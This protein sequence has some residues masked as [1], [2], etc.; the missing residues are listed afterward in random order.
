MKIKNKLNEL[1]Q[2]DL[3]G[4][5][6]FCKY[7]ES[8]K[9]LNI[10]YPFA[11]SN[12]PPEVIEAE[13]A[14]SFLIALAT[15]ADTL[16]QDTLWLGQADY[17]AATLGLENK[18]NIYTFNPSK[19]NSHIEAINSLPK[20]SVHV[21]HPYDLVDKNSY[22]VAPETLFFLN[23]KKKLGSIADAPK[24]KIISLHD[25]VITKNWFLAELEDLFGEIPSDIVVKKGSPSAAGDGVYVGSLDDFNLRS[26]IEG[27]KEIIIE[28]FIPTSA[29]YNVQYFID[30]AGEFH[31]LGYG[32]QHI[33]MH[34]EYDGTTCFLAKAPHQNLLHTAEKTANNIAKFG[35][36]GF[37]G[38]DI[39]EEVGA[40]TNY[41]IDANVR[42][43]AS[44]GPY[45]VKEKLTELLG[46]YVHVGSASI[47]AQDEKKVISMI[48]KHGGMP[49]SISS[50]Y[51]EGMYK[52][53]VLFGG[54]TNTQA[55]ENYDR[56]KEV[57]K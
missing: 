48:E 42:I 55:I 29:N 22:A 16:V 51:G 9:D 50:R 2:K 23:D 34:G 43:N 5:T 4:T 18:I 53:F 15:G 8:H 31:L 54:D 13:T 37:A 56:F 57:M 21:L 52:C 12:Q 41:V 38:F 26:M 46:P 28:Q 27:Q 45:L 39:L 11:D 25:A 17:L 35:Y 14:R 32:K 6:F 19:P 10:I 33:G 44:T 36:F 24:R 3:S 47:T 1:M 30:G 49:C 40:L 20:K 7:P